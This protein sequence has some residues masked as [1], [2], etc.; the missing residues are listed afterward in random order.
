MRNCIRRLNV[1]WWRMK[2]RCAAARWIDGNVLS[3]VRK[4][5]DFIK[6]VPDRWDDLCDRNKAAEWIDGNIIYYGY[7]EPLRMYRMTR[8]WFR[9]NCN[10]YYWR[11]VKSVL[12]SYPWDYGYMMII[13]QAMLE[14]K[15]Y[16][17]TKH[18]MMVDDQYEHILKYLSIARHLVSMMND[19]TSLYHFEGEMEF[20]PIRI[21]PDG[22]RTRLPKGTKA[23]LYELEKGTSKYFYDGP[24]FNMRNC[25]KIMGQKRF[26]ACMRVG[27]MHEMYM[28][29]CKHL[30]YYIRERY[31]EE[32]W[33]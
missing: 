23:E 4:L 8:C 3:Y 5:R 6:T 21:E 27:H 12:F 26:D 14:R 19:D 33:D 13:E 25:P 20:V 10:R 7:T 15:L 17:F 29:K 22:T 11:M 30:Y 2:R 31:T 16:W 9:S 32:W 24:D 18:Q 28:A 1:L